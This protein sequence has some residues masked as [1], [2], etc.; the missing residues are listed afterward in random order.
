MTRYDWPALPREE[1]KDDPGGRVRFTRGFRVDFDPQGARAASLAARQPTQPARAGRGAPRAPASESSNLWQPLGPMTVIDG[2]AIGNSRIAGRI[3]MLAVHPGGERI[4]AAS[5]NG[6]VWYSKDAGL[7]WKSLGGLAATPGVADINRPAQRNACGSIAVVWG[8]TEGNDLVYVGTGETTHGRDAQPGHSLGGIGILRA[9]DPALSTSADPWVREADNLLG[10]GVCRI[11]VQPGGTKVVAATTKGLFE[12]PAGAGANTDW[13]KVPGTPFSDLADK[14]SDVL[15]TKGDATHPERLWVWVQNGDSAGLWVRSGTATNFDQIIDVPPANARR[16][17]FPMLDPNTVPD[18]IYVFNDDG[19]AGAPLLFRVASAA[20]TPVASAVSSVPNVLGKQGFYDI[21]LAVHPVQKDRV[22]LGG[23]TFPAVTPSGVTLLNSGRAPDGA[24][25]VADVANDAGGVLTFGHPNPPQMVGAGVHADIHDLVFSN[26]GNRLWAACDGGVYRSD[27]P[28]NLVGFFAVN[29]GLSVVEANYVAC[30]PTCEGFVVAGLQDNGIITRRSGALWNHDDDGDAGGVAFDPRQPARFFRQYFYG[31]WTSSDGA[32]SIPL[33]ASENSP[34]ECAFYSMPA[35]IA[36]NRAGAP[37]GNQDLTQIILGTSRI[38]YTED[39]GTTWVTLPGGTAPPAANLA[40]DTFGEKITVCRWQSSEV[41]W[42]LSERK[43]KRYARTAGTDTASGPGTWTAADVMPVGVVPSGKQK[44]RPPIPPTMHDSA[45]W[46]DVAVNLDPP[47]GSN[48]AGTPHGTLGA[49]Y[50]GTIGKADNADVDTLW[51]FDGTS[52]WYSTN[53]RKD[54]LGVPAPVISIVCHP[55]LPAHVWV[56]TTVGV[57]HGVRTD[58]GASPPTWVWEG[59][60]NGLPEAAVEDLAIFKDGDLM[61]LR[62]AIA[63]RGVWE[64]RLDVS[65]VQGRTYLRAHDDDLRYRERAQEKKRDLTTNRSWHGSPDVRPRLAPQARAAPASLPWTQATAGIDP[66]L[67]RRF[68]VALRHQTGDL[69]V[70]A[71]G[72]WDGHFNEVLRDLH[73]PASGTT[74]SIDAAFWNLNMAAPHGT[75]EPWSTPLPTEADLFDYT[76][77]LTE[78][79]LDRT[80]SALPAQPLKVDII[81]HQRGLL[82]M[83]GANVRVTLLRWTD[84]RTTNRANPDDHT[85]WLSGDVPWTEA[86]NEVLN[87]DAGTTSQTFADGWSFVGATDATRRQTLSGQTLDPTHPGIAIFDLDLSGVPA[88]TVVL[89]VAVIRASNVITL[90]AD[91]LKEL[92][93]TKAGI[94]VRSLRI[95][96]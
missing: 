1:E 5:A 51:W 2:Q 20:G 48:A 38:W 59:L 80:S 76:P 35:A 64:L 3:N 68:Q 90:T 31:R 77:S 30:H 21:A 18:Q 19:G 44:K 32:F 57:W 78:G 55:D 73:P 82:P 49:V 4:Y 53:L 34:T 56:G 45:I 23:S 70:R 89:L 15:W 87:T 36:K 28:A 7:S 92:V 17:A 67:L 86:V 39:F 65:N 9:Q 58:H 79:D 50:V 47:S 60:V 46:T 40:H 43:L 63:A 22:V 27:D 11:A 25:V 75:A 41:A 10:D 95:A 83:D 62:A 74:V 66:E 91:P 61:L 13:T 37:A 52:Q 12:R 85:T 88:N 29:D 72:R 16:A 24:I 6:G 33:A 84:P 26:N 71:T 94:A 69:R 96:T 42:I 93:L 14:C 54:P 8:S 81:V